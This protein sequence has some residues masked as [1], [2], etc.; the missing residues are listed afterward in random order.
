L[1][2]DPNRHWAHD[3]LL[4]QVRAG[5]R[6]HG[7]D[8][9]DSDED[10]RGFCVPPKRFL[11]GLSS[12]EQWQSEGG[13]HVIFSLQKFVRLAL[14]GNPN[15]IETLFTREQD[16]L[17]THPFAHP[18]LE[19]RDDFLSKNVGLKFGRYAIHQLQKIERHYRWLTTD[20][21]LKPTPQDFGAV[22]GENSP[23]FPNT[24][25]ERAFRGAVKHHRA[26]REWRKNRNPKR[27]LLEEQ[28]GYDTKH[29]MHLC[30]LLKMG[31]EILE[32]GEVH[33][34]RPDADWLRRV[35]QGLLTYQDLLEWVKEQ[36]FA[37]NRAETSS[38]LPEEPDRER[39]EELVLEVTD[40][41]LAEVG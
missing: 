11:Y 38:G 39:A 10:T 19:R 20:P 3:R 2:P 14:D 35:K 33:V 8:T 28:F 36:E 5:S 7:L 24:A 17:F 41:Y 30:R 26:Y 37:L 22:L 27:A 21:P 32:S 40:R 31:T 29:A 12:F 23:K 1:A 34:Y 18:I 25:A 13:D 9:P 16:R 15:I 6:A 4:L